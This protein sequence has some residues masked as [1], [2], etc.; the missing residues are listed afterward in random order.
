[1]LVDRHFR[2]FGSGKAQER[3][4]TK[5]AAEKHGLAPPKYKQCCSGKYT[6][7]FRS[8]YVIMYL[9]QHGPVFQKQIRKRRHASHAEK[10]R[11]I[12]MTTQFPRP[13]LVWERRKRTLAEL[14]KQLQ[15]NVES[16]GQCIS[17]CNCRTPVMTYCQF[18]YDVAC[19]WF[20]ECNLVITITSHNRALR[21]CR[22][23]CSVRKPAVDARRP[24]RKAPVDGHAR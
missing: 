24:L 10:K 6:V 4:V 14:K 18:Q 21:D 12:S 2:S 3:T 17:A 16:L 8:D 13:K 9:R 23:T 20:T 11:K 5:T 7:Q 1:V 22:L 19:M 15:R